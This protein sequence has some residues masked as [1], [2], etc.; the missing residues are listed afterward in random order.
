[1]FTLDTLP[2]PDIFLNRHFRF[3][4]FQGG[5]SHFLGPL[6]RFLHP[7]QT[8]NSA[9]TRLEHFA[10]PH[11]QGS[12]PLSRFS[13]LRGFEE[14]LWAEIRPEKKC[15]A[16]TSHTLMCPI[17]GAISFAFCSLLL[18]KIGF[19]L[20]LLPKAKN[21]GKHSDARFSQKSV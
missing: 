4:L 10:S 2:L 16:G 1:M 20:R 8:G 7:P 11:R 3:V 15:G 5:I 9:I 14:G 13:R 21:A 12:S 18:Q 6:T 19:F 17:S